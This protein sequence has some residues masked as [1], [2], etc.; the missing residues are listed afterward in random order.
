MNHDP[1][2]LEKVPGF[3]D[4]DAQI[5]EADVRAMVRLLGDVIAL[6]GGHREKKTHLMDGLC[7]LVG[8]DAWVWTLACRIEPGGPQTYAGLMHGGFTAPRF[9]RFVEA[10]EHPDMG[11][12]TKCF[13]AEVER[14]CRQTT[15]L[16]HEIDPGEIAL[17]SDVSQ[18]W[19]AADIGSL[20]MS[21]RP[22]DDGSQ[23]G[24]GLYR[25]LLREPF[26]QRQKMIV[27]TV[28]DEVGWLHLTGWPDDRA[29]T[30]PQLS[31]RQ[32]MVLNLLLDGMS[33]KQVSIHLGITEN[34]VSAYARQVYQ[35]FGVHSHQE[36]FRKFMPP[37]S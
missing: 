4:P 12:A 2:K 30:V 22:Y 20:I 1:S 15:M 11:E 28:M 36:L 13:F 5:D 29:A 23:S 16:R 21:T 27:H 35:H 7:R 19:A 8:A 17:K 14:T 25:N 18:I 3:I 26:T 6:H 31:P 9:A 37:E 10:V 33:R 24:I 34:T 32:R